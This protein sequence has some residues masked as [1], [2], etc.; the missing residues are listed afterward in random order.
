MADFVG[1][2]SIVLMVVISGAGLY[3]DFFTRTK[4]T[5][6]IILF[7]L[8]LATAFSALYTFHRGNIDHAKD[9]GRIVQLQQSVKHA[10]NMQETSA[11]EFISGQ[12]EATGV[13]VTKYDEL[14]ARLAALQTGIKTADLQQQADGLRKALKVTQDALVVPKATLSF[15]LKDTVAPTLDEALPVHDDVVHISFLIRNLGT[16]DALDGQIV[17]LLCADCSYAKESSGFIKVN[18]APDNQRN[19]SFQSIPAHSQL[20]L[21]E[22]DIKVLPTDPVIV[23]GVKI[24]C[25]TCEVAPLG[26]PA[27]DMTAHITLLR[28]Q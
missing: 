14:S 15:S 3:P 23:F 17:L 16:V 12:K 9:T 27:P 18:G 28:G 20:Q 4:R 26:P 11:K 7:V 25:R 8:L 6:G 19:F 2:V 22:A 10:E 13:F 24:L 1:Y 5:K 21:F